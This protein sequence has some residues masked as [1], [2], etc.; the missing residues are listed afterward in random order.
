MLPSAVE[1]FL[2][3]VDSPQLFDYDGPGDWRERVHGID[4]SCL[5]EIEIQQAI[6][7]KTTVVPS[8]LLAPGNPLFGL[9]LATAK[10]E[11]PYRSGEVSFTV[12]HD[13]R[14]DGFAGWFSAQLSPSILL[15][16]G[17]YAPKTHWQQVFLP[18]MPF[19]VAKGEVITV[20]Y[21]LQKH[22]ADPRSIAFDLAVEDQSYTFTIA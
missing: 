18:I 12:E 1:V 14:L 16:T 5:E 22:P 11:D 13:G 6:G 8:D 20:R 2:A 19:D 4:F 21:S 3:P 7:I 15:D 17:P 9:D 10:K